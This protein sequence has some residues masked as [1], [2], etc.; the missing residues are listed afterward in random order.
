MRSQSPEIRGPFTKK[1]DFNQGIK[2]DCKSMHELTV[3]FASILQRLLE[4]LATDLGVPSIETGTQKPSGSFSK[5]NFSRPGLCCA[6]SVKPGFPLSP[7]T[8]IPWAP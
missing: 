3:E 1:I 5:S 7:G 4:K 8:L 6:K 2:S